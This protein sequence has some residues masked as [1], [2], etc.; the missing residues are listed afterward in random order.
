MGPLICG[1]TDGKVR[2]LQIKSNKS[3]TLYSSDSL[4]VSLASNSRGTGFLSGHVDGNIIRFFISNE[5]SERE[6]SGRV[7]THSV[8]PC[9]LAWTQ[10]QIF[11]GGCDKRIVVYNVQGK[12][13]KQFDYAKDVSEHEFTSA[14]CS[15]SGQVNIY[16][17][18]NDH[19]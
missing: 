18:I 19:R 7:L 16:F 17:S 3:Q 11:A 6:A 13:V 4:V 5:H 8:P 1:L 10:G 2:T 9:A 15:P 12:V 14:A